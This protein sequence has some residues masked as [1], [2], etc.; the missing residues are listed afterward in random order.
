MSLNERDMYFAYLFF[1]G[2]IE[3][4]GILHIDIE[5]IGVTYSIIECY[6]YKFS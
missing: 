4:I 3:H 2:I 6:K 1:D 5:F